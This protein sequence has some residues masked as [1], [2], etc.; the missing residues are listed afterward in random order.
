MRKE[1]DLYANVRPVSNKQKKIDM[2]I[3]R[4]NTECL[5]VKKE[6]IEDLPDGTKISY[7]TR[8]I[9]EYAS[10]RIGEMGKIKRSFF[11]FFLHSSSINIKFS[12]Q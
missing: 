3:V 9:S 5:Y 11:F 7:A 4:E 2:V 8:I 10:R 1:L 6:K 12:H